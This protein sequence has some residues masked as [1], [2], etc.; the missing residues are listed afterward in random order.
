MSELDLKIFIGMHRSINRLDQNTARLA[1]TKQLTLSQFAV[2]EALYS[3][4][5]MSVGT[6]R[7]RILSTAG[8]IPVIVTN[9]ERRGYVQRCPHEKDRRI[10]IVRLTEAGRRIIQEILPQNLSMIEERFSVFTRAEK[11]QLLAYMKKLGGSIDEK[12]H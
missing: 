8:T 9:L 10:C 5:A 2:L 7:D 3:K 1:Q 6:L 12:N 4:G 11:E